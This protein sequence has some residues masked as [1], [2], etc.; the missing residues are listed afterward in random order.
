MVIENEVEDQGHE[1]SLILTGKEGER[2]FVRTRRRK[3]EKGG[4][5]NVIASATPIHTLSDESKCSSGSIRI[6]ADFTIFPIQAYNRQKRHFLLTAERH[7]EHGEERR[8]KERNSR[9][10]KKMHKAMIHFGL[11]QV[12]C[13]LRKRGKNV[14]G[15]LVNVDVGPS[16]KSK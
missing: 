13:C 10:K 9:E 4:T 5:A 6:P 12:G 16:G 14:N 1:G 15:Y 7:G 11:P 2:A 8:E 3:K